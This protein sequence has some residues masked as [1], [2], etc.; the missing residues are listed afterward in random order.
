MVKILKMKFR[1]DLKLEFGQ[2]LV[3]ILKVAL[4]N[5]LKFNFSPDVGRWCLVEILKLRPVRDSEDEIRSRFV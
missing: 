1:Q 3:E 5:I 2:F 4:V